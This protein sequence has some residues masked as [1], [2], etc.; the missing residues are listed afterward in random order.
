MRRL[1]AAGHAAPR[2]VPSGVA[3]RDL[4]LLPR[5]AHHLGGDTLTIGERFGA[6]VADAGLHV[7]L[8]VGLDDEQAVKADAPRVVGADRHAAAAHLVPYA[9]SVACLAFVPLEHLRALV[10]RLIDE[11]AGRVG[12]VAA[13]IGRS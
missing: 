2:Q 1:A 6:E 10:E 9:L 4:D 3:P 7:H 13:R 5:D 8:A 12:A 11:A